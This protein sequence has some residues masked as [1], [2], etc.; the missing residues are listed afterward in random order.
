[1]ELFC[2]N[3]TLKQRECTQNREELNASKSLCMKLKSVG[4]KQMWKNSISIVYS[5]SYFHWQFVFNNKSH[6]LSLFIANNKIT[7]NSQHMNVNGTYNNNGG[8]MHIHFLILFVWFF[9]PKLTERVER[10]FIK[11]S[12]EFYIQLAL[13]QTM[14][15]QLHCTYSLTQGKL[16][17]VQ[18][19]F[20]P[21][22][23]HRPR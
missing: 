17:N 18:N 10:Q 7:V 5:Y 2:L 20:F 8:K 13:A 15:R 19:N 11:Y 22:W 16:E 14:T 4:F 9:L 3:T 23:A 6:L 1:M 12:R 21:W